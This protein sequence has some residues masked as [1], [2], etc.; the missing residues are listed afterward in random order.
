VREPQTTR[1]ATDILDLII[2]AYGGQLY[3]YASGLPGRKLLKCVT[4]FFALSGG[5]CSRHRVGGSRQLSQVLQYKHA[6]MPSSSILR[7]T[8]WVATRSVTVIHLWK[9]GFINLPTFECEHRK[10]LLRRAVEV[11]PCSTCFFGMPVSQLALSIS[12]I[13]A[14]ITC[15]ITHAVGI[16]GRCGMD[17]YTP[18]TLVFHSTAFRQLGCLFL[19]TIGFEIP[20]PRV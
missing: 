13:A 9:N 8:V 12:G 16:A 19:N 14:R 18:L 6:C 3:Y 2:K 5:D 17:A 15:L 10:Q 11:S 4:R 1:A 7:V 20:H